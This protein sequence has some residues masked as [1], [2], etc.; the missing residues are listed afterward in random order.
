MRPQVVTRVE[1]L[2]A[3]EIAVALKKPGYSDAGTDTFTVGGNAA[4]PV[5]VSGG[6]GSFGGGGNY[7]VRQGDTLWSIA[8]KHYGS[9]QRWKDIASANPG[10]TPEKMRVGMAI[11]L[12]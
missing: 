8:N 7:V 2:V 9:G 4:A 11:V 1:V 5:G 6:G 12:P 3:G 10:L